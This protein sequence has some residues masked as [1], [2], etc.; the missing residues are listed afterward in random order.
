MEPLTLTPKGELYQSLFTGFGEYYFICGQKLYKAFCGSRGSCAKSEKL[1]QV[2]Q[3]QLSV[4]TTI[5]EK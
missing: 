2:T 1:H 5:V 4:K 3:C